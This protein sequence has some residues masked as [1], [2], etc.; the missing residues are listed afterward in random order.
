MNTAPKVEVGRL[1]RA[2]SLSVTPAEPG[3]WGVTGGAARHHVVERHGRL[4]C[5]CIDYRIRGTG[6]K[7]VLAV[8][9]AGTPL[10]ILT[11]LRLLVQPEGVVS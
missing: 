10:D 7:H 1:R 6:C 11:G 5:D 8:K 4:T 9:M 2:L 3:A